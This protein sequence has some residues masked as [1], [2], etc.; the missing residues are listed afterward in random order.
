MSLNRSEQRIEDYLQS[1]KEERQFW[2]AKVRAIVAGEP[3][4]PKAVSR[5]EI[6]LWR[7]YVERSS[8]VPAFKQAVLHEGIART[9]LR[10]L[11]ELMVRLW[12]E[13]R[14]KPK[15]G[16]ASSGELFSDPI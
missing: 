16:V 14:K 4:T 15:A 7:Y 13:P 5:I 11:A 2:Q 1:H 9:S 6:E 10:N 3:D 8:V 12:T